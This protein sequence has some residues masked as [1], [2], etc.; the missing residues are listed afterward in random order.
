VVADHIYFCDSKKETEA[1]AAAPVVPETRPDFIDVDTN[2]LD[3]P[4]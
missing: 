4:F 3:L 1:G 2:D